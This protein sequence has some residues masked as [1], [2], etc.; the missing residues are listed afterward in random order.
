MR[1]CLMSCGSGESLGS[2][3][4]SLKMGSETTYFSE[5]QL[6]RSCSLQRSLQNGNS[7]CTSE[8]VG[9]LQI[10][11]RCCISLLLLDRCSSALDGISRA[12]GTEFAEIYLSAA[13]SIA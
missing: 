7:L 1:Q 9:F 5:A 3:S 8:F 4:S 13:A 12:E 11:Q 2:S 6:P 10:G